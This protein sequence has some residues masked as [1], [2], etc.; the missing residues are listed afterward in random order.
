M[1]DKPHRKYVERLISA[2]L[3]FNLESD[4][5]EGLRDRGEDMQ[6]MT[7]C[8]IQTRDAAF[9]TEPTRYVHYPVTEYVL[10]RSKC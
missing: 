9:R 7:T 3:C 2:L 6:K 8:R 5:E 10:M 4:R 1:H